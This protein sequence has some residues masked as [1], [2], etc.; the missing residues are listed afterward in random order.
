L[1]DPVGRW[2][3][4]VNR[5]GGYW[6]RSWKAKQ[7]FGTPIAR[8]NLVYERSYLFQRYGNIWW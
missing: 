4:R 6:D 2:K 7:E 5:E 1:I 8:Y 3:L